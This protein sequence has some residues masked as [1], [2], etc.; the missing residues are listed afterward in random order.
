MDVIINSENGDIISQ[1][2]I[3]HAQFE[4]IHPFKDGNGRIGRILI[5]IYLYQRQF[6]HRP[7][8]YL[9]EFLE[10]HRDEY[11]DSLSHISNHNEWQGWVE[12]FLHAVE[13]QA[14]KN[15][16]KGKAVLGLYA[17]LKIEFMRLTKSQYAIPALDA[18]FAVP[19]IKS[20]DFIEKAGIQNRATANTILSQLESGGFISKIRPSS[21][22]SPAIYVLPEILNIAEGKKYFRLNVRDSDF[23][24][25]FEST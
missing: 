21:G 6:L 18:F 5:P 1:L 24:L 19:V 22:R 8:F 13:T 3:I 15:F 12:F 10:E 17:K 2:G 16:E 20:S 11:C 9:S 23:D 7:M 25:I 4:I 14:V